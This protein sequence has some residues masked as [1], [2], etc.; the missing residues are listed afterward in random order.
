MVPRTIIMA[1]STDLRV[2]IQFSKDWCDEDQ[3]LHV[4]DAL[5]VHRGEPGGVAFVP[6]CDDLRQRDRAGYAIAA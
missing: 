1:P 4:L 5:G 6:R 3:V 2:V